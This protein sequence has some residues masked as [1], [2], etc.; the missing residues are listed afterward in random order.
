M[1]TDP[2][3][4]SGPSAGGGV[5]ILVSTPIGNMSDLSP[6]AS[7]T[8]ETADIVLAEDTRRSS[9]LAGMRGRLVSY[10]DHNAAGRL[11]LIAERLSAGDTIAL[12]TDAGMPGISDPC[13]RAVRMALECGARVEVVP[14]PSAALTALVASGLP[15]DRFF[16]EGFL[17]HKPGPRAARL[18]EMALYPHTII[19][20]VGPHHAV[21]ILSDILEIL[22]DRQACLAREMTK[23]HEEYIRGTVSSILSI[24]SARPPRGEITLVVA[25]AVRVRRAGGG[26]G[27]D[28]GCDGEES[29]DAAEDAA[30]QSD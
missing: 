6:R 21:R 28:A 7:S 18:R 30:I 11:P 12:V 29:G 2:G 3:Y 24:V 5:L 8:L 27:P 10:N 26:A 16:F 1:A 9:R 14:G 15:P 20:F 23:L 17:P 4:S 19:I 25:G 22:G 13:F